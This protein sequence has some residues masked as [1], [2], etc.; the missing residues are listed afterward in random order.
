MNR[1]G[2]RFRNILYFLPRLILVLILLG[3]LGLMVASN[4]DIFE[5]YLLPLHAAQGRRQQ[6]SE[7]LT[8]GPYPHPDDLRQLQREGVRGIISLLDTSLPQERALNQ[9]EEQ[10]ARQLGLAFWNV[11]LGYL[12]LQ[13]EQNRQAATVVARIVSGRPGEK[14]YMHCYLGR[15]RVS[16]IRDAL[17]E[18]GL[19]G[20][21]GAAGSR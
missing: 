4:F 6:L 20:G 9:V 21:G 5:P 3:C 7:N 16:F 17:K 19:L 18:K 10:T 13:S 2:A 12:S 1:Q 11:P 8:I 14:L 15:H